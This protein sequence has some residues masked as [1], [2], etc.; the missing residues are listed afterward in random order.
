MSSFARI[1]SG[2]DKKTSSVTVRRPSPSHGL[3]YHTP[4]SYHS[5][6]RPLFRLPTILV[7]ADV[8]SLTP[9]TMGPPATLPSPHASNDVL[10]VHPTFDEALLLL[11]IHTSYTWTQ[12]VEI[13]NKSFEMEVDVTATSA[14][15]M[16]RQLMSQKE[17]LV[18][19][20]MAFDERGKVSED[21]KG[22]VGKQRCE[23]W[24]EWFHGVYV[25]ED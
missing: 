13:L 25:A 1:H 4:S 6:N 7:S 11:S 22:F 21:I 16:R 10:T 19:E 15:V 3:A 24:L 23:Q 2:S 20:V 18:T 8:H 12:I 14:E 5:K 17:V 9:F